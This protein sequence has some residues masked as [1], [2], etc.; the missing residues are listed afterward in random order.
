MRLAE[1][2]PSRYENRKS[3]MLLGDME[4]VVALVGGEYS[5]EYFQRFD[6]SRLM[7]ERRYRGNRSFPPLVKIMAD[8]VEEVATSNLRILDVGCAYGYLVKELRERGFEAFGLD[9]SQDCIKNNVA[10]E[11]VTFGDISILDCLPEPGA[12]SLVICTN[13]FEHLDDGQLDNLFRLLSNADYLFAIISKSPHDIT[14]I[15]LKSYFEWLSICRTRHW[16]LYLY[17]T[18]AVRN[19]YL[20]DGDGSEGWNE[21]TFVFSKKMVFPKMNLLPLLFEYLFR[22]SVRRIRYYT[23]I[24]LRICR[25]LN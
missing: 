22:S 16:Q 14:H 11:Y 15:N 12:F 1:Q 8:M 9:F 13:L 19:I 7:L 6:Y 5:N 17:P 23:E 3:R 20:R 24:V 25:S 2:E 18:L 21:N 4:D 10:S